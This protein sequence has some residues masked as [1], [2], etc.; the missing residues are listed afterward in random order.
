VTLGFVTIE[1]DGNPR[2][3]IAGQ[4]RNVPDDQSTHD[5][6]LSMRWKVHEV[7]SRSQ[8][9]MSRLPGVTYALSRYR[10]RARMVDCDLFHLSRKPATA[11]ERR[12]ATNPLKYMTCTQ[13]LP[14][15][16][17]RSL[18]NDQVRSRGWST[19]MPSRSNGA[20]VSRAIHWVAVVSADV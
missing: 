13:L 8:E 12:P 5:A 19:M 3:S 2:R 11:S 9:R 15:R 10:V 6:S 1:R 18:S 16:F 4:R 17:C 20:S 14:G 7:P